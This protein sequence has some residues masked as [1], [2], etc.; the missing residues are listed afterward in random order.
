[1]KMD[2]KDWWMFLLGL[3]YLTQINVIGYLGISELA[4][5]F[6]A[7][8][9]LVKHR[10]LLAKWGMLPFI[11]LSALWGV[12]ALISCVWNENPWF[13][14]LKGF[15]PAYTFFAEGVC[16]FCLLHDS[17]LRLKWGILGMTLSWFLSIFVF[18]TG[19]SSAVAEITGVSALEAV[20]DY[21]LFW[22]MLVHLVTSLPIR[23]AFLHIPLSVSLILTG[24]AAIFS[25]LQGGRSAFAMRLVTMYLLILGNKLKSRRPQALKVNIVLLMA[26]LLICSV[27]SKNIYVYLARHNYLKAEEIEKYEKQSSHGTTTTVTKLL[28][29]GRGGTIAGVLI[30]AKTP[31]LGRGYRPID[32]NEEYLA[33]V[34]KYSS[35]DEELKRI[36]EAYRKGY[37]ELPSHSHIVEGW[38]QAGFGGLIF[39]LYILWVLIKAVKNNLFI[40]PEWFGYLAVILPTVFWDIFFS[41]IA[42]RVEL[43]VVIVC[44][45]MLNRLGE[46]RK[47]GR[48]L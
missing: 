20:V 16:V 31:I 41:P 30:A 19:S 1:M 23:L 15:A 25:V 21:K 45:L 5:Y 28:M 3:F 14:I 47:R 11:Y 39:W 10:Q 18:Q 35:D 4:C 13:S 37:I 27:I 2:K 8:Y 29:G 6:F 17:P 26:G 42:K 40:V 43:S 36:R 48:V 46:M 9:L 33:F 12:F 22:V 7:P 38:I 44:C 32:R 34:E 24:G